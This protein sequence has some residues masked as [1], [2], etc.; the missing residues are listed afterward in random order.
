MNHSWNLILS[1]QHPMSTVCINYCYWMNKNSYSKWSMKWKCR[2]KSLT[3]PDFAYL[4][5]SGWAKGALVTW[6][7]VPL[8]PSTSIRTLCKSRIHFGDIVSNAE[9]FLFKVLNQQLQ[10]I[11]TNNPFCVFFH[12]Y[13]YVYCLL[14]KFLWF[15]SFVE[16]YMK[17]QISRKKHTQQNQNEQQQQ[18]NMWE[19][20]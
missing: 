2:D 14:L 19:K 8:S 18:K 20:Y 7:A 1:Q 10:C 5:V 17:F 15:S 3:L 6:Y 4:I 11:V 16:Y 13:K 12:C 9:L